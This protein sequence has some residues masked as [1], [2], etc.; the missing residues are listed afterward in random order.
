VRIQGTDAAAADVEGVS[1]AAQTRLH[2][3]D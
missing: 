3:E 2:V 1:T